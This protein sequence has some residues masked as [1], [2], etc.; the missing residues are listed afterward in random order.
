ML[1]KCLNLLFTNFCK[2]I[3][4]I[5]KNFSFS[6]SFSFFFLISFQL[7]QQKILKK[8]QKFYLVISLEN[9][10]GKLISAKMSTQ[11]YVISRKKSHQE[12]VRKIF[13]KLFLKNFYR[14]AWIKICI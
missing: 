12:R 8:N 1:I 14:T 7:N 10:E 6:F 9:N 13:L 4:F 3:I 2:V 5:K 11:L